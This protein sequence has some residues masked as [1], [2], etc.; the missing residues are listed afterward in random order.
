MQILE[1]IELRKKTTLR[2]GGTVPFFYDIRT[3]NAL[4]ELASI[5]EKISMPIHLLGGGSNL[6]IT[7]ESMGHKGD[8]LPFSVAQIQISYEN[9]DKFQDTF[10]WQDDELAPPLA[11]QYLAQ[12]LTEKTLRAEVGSG[13]ALQKFL[14]LCAEKGCTGLEGLVGIPGKIGGAVAMNAGA[15][16][17]EI[18][19]V[20]ETVRIF[21][22]EYGFLDLTRH[23]FENTYRSFIPYYKGVKLQDF[24]ISGA[25][26]VF[27][28]IERDK[29]KA[30]MHEHLL[31]K[32]S[33]QPIKAFTAGCVFKNP[34]LHRD[35]QIIE[36]SK[37]EKTTTEK[38][39]NHIENIEKSK[40]IYKTTVEKQSISAGKLLDEAGMKG[41]EHGGMRFSP[42]HANFLEN[43]GNGTISSALAL[44]EEAIEKVYSHTQIKLEKEV[45]VWL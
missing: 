15:Y 12:N 7:D 36:I 11:K 9:E 6:L 31:A 32:K 2:L 21:H 42:I 26:F 5:E 22:K 30:N 40:E 23:N 4:C 39:V 16:L 29:V 33:T 44:I 20:L 25:S 8:I 19:K 13:M 17:S 27:P 24:I 38:N 28:V 37:T 14:K 3:E 43:I 10:I 18:D 35:E 1:N 41:K 45:K 34:E